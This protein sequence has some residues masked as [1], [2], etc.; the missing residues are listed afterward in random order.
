MFDCEYSATRHVFGIF[1]CA[2]GNVRKQR[3]AYIRVFVSM[4]E[5]HDLQI[6]LSRDI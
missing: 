3:K 1:L 6:V 5:K 2:I 4:T